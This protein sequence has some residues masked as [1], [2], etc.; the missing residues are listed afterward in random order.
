MLQVDGKYYAVPV[1]AHRANVLWTNPAVLQKAGVTW[2]ESTT[3]DQF[4]ADLP[5]IQATGATPICLGDKDIFA[6]AQLLESVLISKLGPDG[7]RGLFTGQHAVR[8]AR[9]PLGRADLRHACSARPTP[10]TAALT[11]D[12]AVVNMTGG[13][14]AATLMGDWAYGEMVNKG[15][16]EGT[17]FGYLPFPGTKRHLRLRRR[18]LRDPGRERPEPR[19]GEGLAVGPARPAGPEGLQPGQGLLTGPHRRAARRVPGLPAVAAANSLRSEQ[20]VSSLAHGQAAAGEFAQ[21]YADAVSTFNGGQDV[22]AF[23]STMSS[24]QK[25]QLAQS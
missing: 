4:V 6:S 9:R 12:Q 24:A 16:K 5:K 19:G 1:N 11:W 17:D 21:T 25:T 14:C 7:W 15:K 10:T 23:I 13:K 18:R 22:D 20:I 3:L 8:L 2:N